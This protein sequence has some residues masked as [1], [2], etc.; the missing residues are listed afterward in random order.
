MSRKKVDAEGEELTLS[1]ASV[2]ALSDYVVNCVERNPG[3]TKLLLTIC[4]LV[5]LTRAR[6]E[7]KRLLRFAA[8]KEG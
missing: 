2:E 8:R 1:A 4:D 5:G 6:G 3:N 7:I